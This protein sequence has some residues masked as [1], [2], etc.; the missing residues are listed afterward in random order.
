MESRPQ[1]ACPCCGYLVIVDT[2]DTCPI[3]GWENDPVQSSD[4]TFEDGANRA[5]LH[6]AQENFIRTGSADVPRTVPVRAP[7]ATDRRWPNWRLQKS[8]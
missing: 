6:E 8:S 2:F 4:P 7:T 1:N 5:S 3:C